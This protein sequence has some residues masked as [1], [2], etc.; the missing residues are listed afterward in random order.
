MNFRV[1]RAAWIGIA[2]IVPAAPSAAQQAPVEVAFEV[3]LN[4]TR[5][6][7]NI[8]KIRVQCELRSNAI[9]E[10]ISVPGSQALRRVVEVEIPVTQG[11]VVQT[12][13][14]RH[15]VAAPGT[16]QSLR[17]IGDLRMP[18]TRVRLHAPG[19][20]ILRRLRIGHCQLH[21]ASHARPGGDHGQFCL[22]MLSR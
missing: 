11:E 5:L 7:S 2:A 16:Q 19:L 22:V 3:P 13:P 8:P 12:A 17:Q 15:H 9:I 20:D 10:S 21:S 6:A 4:L 14:A 18:A 1:L